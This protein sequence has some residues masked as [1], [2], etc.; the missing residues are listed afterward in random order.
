MAT[1]SGKLLMFSVGVV[2]LIWLISAV[3]GAIYLISPSDTAVNVET[4]GQTVALIL[5][6]VTTVAIWLGLLVAV[7]VIAWK[8]S[9]RRPE[10]PPTP[11]AR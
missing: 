6:A 3:V 4:T 7:M 1:K 11:S 9:G 2:L 10:T 8:W 5:F